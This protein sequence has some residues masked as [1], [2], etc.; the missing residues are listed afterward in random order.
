[1]A[2]QS[3]YSSNVQRWAA[4]CIGVALT[5]LLLAVSAPPAS[6]HDICTSHPSDPDALGS[7][8]ANSVVCMRYNHSRLDV[9]DRHRDGHR[10]Y[11]RTYAIFSNVPNAPLYDTN[12]ADSGC[13]NYGVALDMASFNVCVEYEG[14]GSPV[15][16]P[17]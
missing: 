4:V 10:V 3:K 16:R 15:Y 9:C 12:G 17:F 5:A 11:A 14:C 8:A 1:M 6:A 13:G 7:G 2:A